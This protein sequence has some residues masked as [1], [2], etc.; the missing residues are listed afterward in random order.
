MPHKKL[1]QIEEQESLKKRLIQEAHDRLKLKAQF[2]ENILKRLSGVKDR[3]IFSSFEK[4]DKKLL[5][6]EATIAGIQNLT[7]STAEDLSRK[8]E[9]INEDT[10]IEYELGKISNKIKEIKIPEA[11]D[12]KGLKQEI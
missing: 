9:A 6:L 4:I 7:A 8:I 10:S 1:K 5:E 11:I 3:D 2:K 12:T